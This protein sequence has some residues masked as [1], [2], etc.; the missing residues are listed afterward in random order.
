MITQHWIVRVEA[1]V[2][3]SRSRKEHGKNKK[4]ASG[5]GELNYGLS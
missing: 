1:S 5:T 4:E 3:V 2:V